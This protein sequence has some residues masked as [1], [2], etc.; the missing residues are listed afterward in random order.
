MKVLHVSAGF[1]QQGGGPHVILLPLVG[2]LNAL[3]VKVDLA[4]YNER[5]REYAQGIEAQISTLDGVPFYC[6]NPS[7]LETY[8]FSLSFSMWLR[9]HIKD[10][11]L[12]HIHGL[13]TWTFLSAAY[14]SRLY[15][16]PYIVRTQG[17]LNPWCL[18]KSAILKKSFLGTFGRRLLNGAAT[19]HFTS[20]EEATAIER[21]QL[22]APGIVIPNGVDEVYLNN[23]V[24]K[25][26]FRRRFPST[27]GKKLILFLSRIDPKKGL[28]L[29]LQAVK[30]LFERWNDFILIIAGAGEDAYEDKIKG[31][32]RD[33]NLAER[34]IFTGFVQGEEKLS[35]LRDS[36]VF[37]LP[38]Y[39]ENFGVAVA[40]AMASGLPV[41]VSK[42]VNIS[43]KIK[44]YGAGIV[45]GYQPEEIASALES[46]LN[47]DS[48]RIEMGGNGKRLVEEVYNWRIIGQ[49]LKE[50]YEAILSGNKPIREIGFTGRM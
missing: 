13:F 4:C 36:D 50:L 32:V 34:A 27:Q 6:F 26:T 24:P 47:D 1:H 40:E 39:D 29:L 44:E 46:L 38:S 21:L 5:R 28:E 25:G 18:K 12:I 23:P 35:L 37:V 15:K 30:I 11:D 9:Q 20:E 48:L 49:R 43:P 3:G 16:K 7:F 2:T 14:Y 42:G 41:C 17:V 19:I 8:D 33:N 22:K 10:Y 45:T 31:L